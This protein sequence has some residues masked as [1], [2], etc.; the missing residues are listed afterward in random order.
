M[1]TEKHRKKHSVVLGA[2]CAA[3]LMQ[4]RARARKKGWEKE[5]GGDAHARCR[6]ARMGRGSIVMLQLPLQCARRE[7]GRGQQSRHLA[8]SATTTWGSEARCPTKGSAIF[9]GD[10]IEAKERGANPA[11]GQTDR[12]RCRITTAGMLRREGWR[13]SLVNPPTVLQ[14]P[15]GRSQSYQRYTPNVSLRKKREKSSY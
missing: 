6:W 13:C 7:E 2:T 14:C 11:S 1:L 5:L 10:D 12:A 8:S 4:Q 15:L 9:E 3:L